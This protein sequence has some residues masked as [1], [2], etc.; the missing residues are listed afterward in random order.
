MVAFIDE[1]RARWGIEPIC[2]VLPIAPSTY[3]AFKK[4]PPS[5]RALRDEYLKVEIEHVW[6]TNFKVY[7]GRKVYKQMN[8]DEIRVAK[9]TVERLMRQMGIQGARRGRKV[10]TTIPAADGTERPADLVQR[11]FSA[12]APN[13]LWLCD[14]TYVKTHSGMVYVA[15]VIDGF[16]RMIVGW[17][18]ARSLRTDLCLDALE[19]AV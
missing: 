5:D 15:F 1:N 8:R 11:N 2:R 3:H 4:R 12:P 19:Q 6:K 13:R 16:A 9:C 10:F 17:Q 7:G 18:A 14:I